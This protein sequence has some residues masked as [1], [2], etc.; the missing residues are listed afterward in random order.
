[1][2]FK[3]L[4]LH[5]WIARSLATLPALPYLVVEFHYRNAQFFIF[6]LVAA[7]LLAARQHPL[8]ASFALALGINLKVR[9]I[10]FLPY[11]AAPGLCRVV[12]WSVCATLGFALVRGL[13]F[14]PVRYAHLLSDW[15]TQEGA[16]ASA[17]GEPGIIGFPSQSLH[18]VMMRY[19]T[20]IDYSK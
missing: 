9:P 3:R 13:V 16:V 18:S 10:L 11:L 17:A 1:A 19:L 2:L 20:S 7:A 12:S 15:T 5:G 8:G 6:A 14:G 4:Q